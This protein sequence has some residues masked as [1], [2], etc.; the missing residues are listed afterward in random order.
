[1]TVQPWRALVVG[2]LR[3]TGPGLDGARGWPYSGRMQE[4]P[5]LFSGP[6]VRAILAGNPTQT[7]RVLTPQ[8]VLHPVGTPTWYPNADV[9]R[10]RAYD[11]ESHFRCGAVQDHARWQPGDRL[12]VRE[13][14]KVGAWK[15]GDRFAI[16]YAAGP[17]GQTPWVR[18]PTDAAARLAC[19]SFTDCERYV[20]RASPDDERVSDEGARYTWEVGNS[21]CR[22]RPSIFMPR[23]ASRLTL[24]VV[25]VR[26]QRLQDISKEDAVAEG[27]ADEGAFADLWDAINGKRPG[28]A[29][30]DNPWVWAI[31]FRRLP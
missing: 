30:R 15:S 4:R 21:P 18:P 16:D 19:E 28:C 9:P 10:G 3:M 13:T 7:R 31:T 29:W 27:A 6:M 5:I 25:E 12:W 11:G 17:V 8:P 24:D 1:M 14:W 22:W 2:R 23:W 26:V 20:E